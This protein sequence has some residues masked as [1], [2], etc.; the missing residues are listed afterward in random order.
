MTLNDDELDD[1][2]AELT[3]PS[4]PEAYHRAFAVLLRSEHPTAVC[5]ALDDYQHQE[6]LTRFGGDNPLEPFAGEVLSV[7]RGLLSRPAGPGT[8]VSALNV[9]RNLAEHEDADLIADALDGATDPDVLETG[10]S[11]AA[12][13]LLGEP[14]PNRRLLTVLIDIVLDESRDVDER[15]GAL[16]ALDRADTPDVE[17]ALVRASESAELDL[18]ISAA[19]RLTMPGRIR[20]HRERVERLV[21]SWPED[22]GRD[23]SIVREQ[24]AGFHSLHWTDAEPADPELRGA[25]R[26]L[27]FPADDESCLQAFLTLLRSDD[28]VAVG[29]ALDHYEHGEGLRRVLSDEESAE[30]HLPEVLARARE[31]LRQPPSP[32]ELSPECGAGANHVSALNLIS[33]QHATP[34]DA[35]LVADL[36]TRA[37]TDRVLDKAI[38]MAYGVLDEAEVKDQRIVDALSDLLSGPWPRFSPVKEKAIR[39]L[40]DGL[41][42]QADDVL[43]RLVR[44]DDARAQAYAT[45]YLV[46]TGGLGRYRDLL[47]EVAESWGERSPARPWGSDVVGLVLGALHSAYWAPL[48]LADPGLHRAHREL[49]APTSQEACHRALRTLLGSGD[50]VAV[51]IALDHW[52][53]PAGIEH[54]FGEE[55]RNAEASLVLDR[56]GEALRQPPSPAEL[57]PDADVGA[58]HLSALSALRFAGASRAALLPDVLE[59]LADVLEGAASDWIRDCAMEAV[60]SVFEDAE[61]ADPRLVEALGNVACDRDVRLGDRLAAIRALEAS[62]GSNAA[63]VL[64]RV[65][66]CP[67][68]EIQAAAAWGLCGEETFEEHRD[69]LGRLSANWPAED[70]PWQAEQVRDL[71]GPA[72]E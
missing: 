2:L 14:E 11:A 23:T 66:E 25:H 40:A 60:S 70:V 27:M 5:A 8:R 13:A 30:R 49:R 48:R 24:L 44:G 4:G 47:V 39:V 38:W 42:A 69:L 46:R 52:W 22:A 59:A 54:H 31:V 37:A 57:T 19:L 68:V 43:L 7:A 26:E 21:A 64:V 41:G 53:N 20:T 61:E 50:Q 6:A 9:M 36:L 58:N 15:R 33:A 67:E 29:I 10:L 65:T 18:Q 35:D 16:S 45:Y 32:A 56:V 51:G 63:P 12:A 62:P 1:M 3:T 34:S 71:L 72:D 55:A 28:P 17:D